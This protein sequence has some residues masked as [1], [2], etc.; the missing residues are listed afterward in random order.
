MLEQLSNYRFSNSNKYSITVLFTKCHVK[1]VLGIAYYNSV[2]NSQAVSIISEGN[3]TIYHTAIHEL[4]HNLGADHDPQDSFKPKIMQP[5][6]K[7]AH[8]EFVEFSMRSQDQMCRY[9]S[10]RLKFLPN[11]KCFSNVEDGKM[12]NMG[13]L[14]LLFM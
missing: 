14:L 1:N 4:G 13:F 5:T 11:Y 9:L 12:V 8:K 6:L 3:R 10:I 7:L 2:C